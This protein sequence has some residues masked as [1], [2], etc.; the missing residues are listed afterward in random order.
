MK[1]LQA[2]AGRL[3]RCPRCMRQAFAATTASLVALAV[4]WVYFG[5]TIPTAILALAAS[6]LG[7][8]WI[9][10]LIAYSARASVG[11]RG[12][13]DEVPDF[14]RRALFPTFMKTLGVVAIATSLPGATFARG[15]DD[16][17][18]K[19]CQEAAS[20]CRSECQDHY[21]NDQKAYYNCTKPCNDQFNS[22]FRNCPR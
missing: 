19:R 14:S 20:D 18:P 6:G 1:M 5:P 7:C 8:L 21:A 2:F 12:S 22:C 13:Q 11:S 10:H 9:G 3:G 15:M 16:E 17:C 4:S